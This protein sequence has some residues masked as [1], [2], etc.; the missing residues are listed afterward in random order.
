VVVVEWAT[1]HGMPRPTYPMFLAGVVAMAF[2]A[3]VV[4]HAMGR[5]SGDRSFRGDDGDA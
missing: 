1:Q 3:G 4:G 5:R 2:G